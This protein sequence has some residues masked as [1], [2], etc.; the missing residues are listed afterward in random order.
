MAYLHALKKVAGTSF[1]LTFGLGLGIGFA[2]TMDEV[3]YFQM[4]KTIILPM[5]MVS[6]KKQQQLEEGGVY[7]ASD[8]IDDIKTVGSGA[9]SFL[10]YMKPHAFEPNY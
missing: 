3:I 10:D 7:S 1:G 9:L 2:S 5:M 4:R 8:K 6:V